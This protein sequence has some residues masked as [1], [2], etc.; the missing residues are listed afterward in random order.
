M[1]GGSASTVV[2]IP[3]WALIIMWA[4]SVLG[5]YMLSK[6]LLSRVEKW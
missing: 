2:K 4:S 1:A 6:D 3:T 5:I